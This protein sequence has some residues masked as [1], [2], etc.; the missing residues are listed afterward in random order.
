MP[1]N[2]V[3][4]DHLTLNAKESRF[5][6]SRLSCYAIIFDYAFGSKKGYSFTVRNSFVEQFLFLAGRGLSSNLTDVVHAKGEVAEITSGGTITS[7]PTL[8]V[9]GAATHQLRLLPHRLASPTTWGSFCAPRR[10]AQRRCTSPFSAITPICVVSHHW[11]LPIPS[12]K[13]IHLPV[14]GEHYRIEIIHRHG[15][16]CLYL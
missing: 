13:H 15:S 2:A 5:D 11:P 4:R 12:G 9:Y 8:K 7:A 16:Q 1:L 6:M 10:S 3:S 14:D